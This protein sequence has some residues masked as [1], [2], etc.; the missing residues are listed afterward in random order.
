MYREYVTDRIAALVAEREAGIISAFAL[1]RLNA[2]IALLEAS[3]AEYDDLVAR[4]FVITGMTSGDRP[5]WQ[6]AA[7]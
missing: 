4:G 5:A 3:L 6:A 2:R 1:M 7:P